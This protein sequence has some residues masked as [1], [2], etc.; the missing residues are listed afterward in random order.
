VSAPADATLAIKTTIAGR[1]EPGFIFMLSLLF[2]FLFGS[3]IW[4]VIGTR[5]VG[6]VKRL[7]LVIY[8]ILAHVCPFLFSVFQI[9]SYPVVSNNRIIC[10]V[11]TGLEL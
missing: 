4:P 6:H 2:D 8:P 9:S 3:R 10:L 11:M 1:N 7:T 5:R